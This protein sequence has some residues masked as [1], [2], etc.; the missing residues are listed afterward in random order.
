MSA[1][2]HVTSL[3][4]LS[5]RFRPLNY[6]FMCKLRIL[7]LLIPNEYH[8]T[9]FNFPLISIASHALQNKVRSSAFSSPWRKSHSSLQKAGVWGTDSPFPFP[10]SSTTRILGLPANAS[11]WFTRASFTVSYPAST[12][13]FLSPI[14]MLKTGPYVLDSYSDE[15]RQ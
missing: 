14:W 7:S 13:I 8:H 11:A 1:P 5:C 15:R 9:L 2:H 6:M 4:R 3:G 12:T 10:A